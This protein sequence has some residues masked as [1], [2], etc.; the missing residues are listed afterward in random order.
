[1]SVL[2]EFKQNATSLKDEVVQYDIVPKSSLPN[3]LPDNTIA[4]D[5]VPTNFYKE[6]YKYYVVEGVLFYNAER[7]SLEAA[8][9]V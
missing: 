2:I 3:V 4:V 9:G 5:S 6:W 1:M 7:I 8:Q